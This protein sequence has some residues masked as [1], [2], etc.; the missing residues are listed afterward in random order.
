MNYITYITRVSLLVVE[1]ANQ[2]VRLLEYSR[3]VRDTRH[4]HAVWS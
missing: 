1:R 4:A 3:A 2:L